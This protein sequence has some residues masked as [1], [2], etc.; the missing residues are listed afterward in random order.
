MHDKFTPVNSNHIFTTF[1]TLTDLE[2]KPSLIST[3]DI[4]FSC[5]RTALIPT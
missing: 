1:I 3:S 2:L 4:I 5:Y